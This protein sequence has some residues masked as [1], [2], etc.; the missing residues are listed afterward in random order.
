MDFGVDGARNLFTLS[1]KDRSRTKTKQNFRING[2]VFLKEDSLK[3][4][5]SLHKIIGTNPDN[6]GI[7]RSVTLL[8]GIDDNSDCEQILELS[9]SNLVL[10]LEANYIDSQRGSLTWYQDD[11]SLEGSQLQNMLSTEWFSE[12]GPLMHL[13]NHIFQSQ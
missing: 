6:Q 13:S 1:K 10:I 12:T 5:W 4:Q 8:L 9:I 2:I 7:V 3:K 11:E